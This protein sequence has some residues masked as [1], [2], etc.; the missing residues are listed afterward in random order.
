[1]LGFTTEFMLTPGVNSASTWFPRKNAE[2][3][4]HNEGINNQCT[5]NVTS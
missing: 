3:H 1:M 5:L 4:I 2:L